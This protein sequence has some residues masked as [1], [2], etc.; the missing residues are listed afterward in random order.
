MIK[1]L[2]TDDHPV[3]RQGIRQILEASNDFFEVDEAASGV[4]LMGKICANT[5]SVILMDISLPGRS[6][7][8]M[9][10]QIK[11]F[12]PSIPVLMLSIHPE[13]QYAIRAFKLG[14]AGY[15]TKTS[16]PDDLIN[17]IRKVVNGGKYL[18]PSLAEYLASQ[19]NTDTD[20]PP[21]HALSPRELEVMR[22]IAQ[23]LSPK[24]IGSS[25]TISAKTVS[26]YRERIMLKLQISTTSEIIRYAIINGL[27]A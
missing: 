25:L 13:E 20:H 7:L 6:G 18:T 11:S 15:L 4:E 10:Q 8:E 1:V 14:A 17:A 26:T 22:L 23:G 2:I 19:I 12:R 5:Y 9:L 16:A 21:H 24:E 3:V 27:V